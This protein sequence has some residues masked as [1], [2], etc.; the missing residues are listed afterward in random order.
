M[1]KDCDFDKSICEALDG[2]EEMKK[3]REK[4]E[5]YERVDKMEQQLKNQQFEIER[6]L[7]TQYKNEDLTDIYIPTLNNESLNQNY[8]ES[9]PK[10]VRIEKD[11]NGNTVITNTTYKQPSIKDKENLE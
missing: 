1:S 3:E 4:E 11:E 2:L 7:E 8:I 10:K 9:G 6:S 5:L